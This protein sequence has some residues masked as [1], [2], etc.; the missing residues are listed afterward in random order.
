MHEK[1]STSCNINHENVEHK[2]AY[3]TAAFKYNKERERQGKQY[4]H[5]RTLKQQSWW[6]GVAHIAGNRT[7]HKHDYQLKPFK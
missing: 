1:R 3:D 2:E 5:Y 7:Q 4:L 6:L